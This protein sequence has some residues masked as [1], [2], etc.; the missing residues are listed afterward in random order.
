MIAKKVHILFFLTVILVVG[1]CSDNRED[2][3][4]LD[5]HNYKLRPYHDSVFPDSY[6]PHDLTKKEIAKCQQLVKE[7]VESFNKKSST[8]LNL[9][10]YGQQYIGA[11]SPEGEIMVYVNCFCNPEKY[12]YREKYLVVVSDGGDCFFHLV[13]NLAKNEIVEG[14]THGSA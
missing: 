4:L 7:A 9:D 5:L 11:L 6:Q 10:Q 8:P 3:Y 1:T 2:Y 13:I 12:D 14:M